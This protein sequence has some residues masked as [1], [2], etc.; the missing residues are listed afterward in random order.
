MQVFLKQSTVLNKT[1][2]N[3]KLKRRWNY[4]QKR[5]KQERNLMKI[6]NYLRK[7]LT[8][9]FRTFQFKNHKQDMKFQK[10]KQKL[11][12][13]FLKTKKRFNKINKRTLKKSLHLSEK[14]FK[15][16]ILVRKDKVT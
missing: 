15:N 11:K 7:E 1:C 2:Q 3:Q 9:I 6:E 10:C 4:R 8:I 13:L 12:K 14:Q 16:V 5:M